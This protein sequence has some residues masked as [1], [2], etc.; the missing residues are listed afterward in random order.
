MRERTPEKC[1]FWML[2]EK[3]RS[4]QYGCNLFE[5]FESPPGMI[6]WNLYLFSHAKKFDIFFWWREQWLRK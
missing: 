6:D 4:V 3:E 1:L 2:S 5:N